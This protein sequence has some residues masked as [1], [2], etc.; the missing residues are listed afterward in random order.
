M[1]VIKELFD[2]MPDGREVYSYTI[3]NE[4]G[5]FVRFL[6]YGGI[7]QA[8]TVPDK[9]GVLGDV[10][11]GF[12]TIGDYRKSGDYHGAMVG[13]YCNRIDHGTFLLNGK[14][15]RLFCNEK[16]KQHLH[17]GNV[18]YNARLWYAEILD[19]ETVRFSLFSPDGDEGYPGNMTVRVTC[20]FDGY[21]LSL[22][23]E[24]TT[25]ADTVCSLTNHAYF[26]LNGIGGSSL[27]DQ[28]LWINADRYCEV[29]DD[30]IPVGAPVPVGKTL[31]DYTSPKKLATPIDHNSVLRGGERE[32][33]RAAMVCDPASGRALIVTTDL[34][35]IQVYTAGGMDKPVPFK[36][37][38]PQRPLHAIALETQFFPDSPNRPDFPSPVLKAGETFRSETVYSFGLM[39][40]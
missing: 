39:E 28:L 19:E 9:N 36:G 29:N 31:F 33:K 10:V 21:N 4:N 3:R 35:G 25:D 14:E 11:C 27:E 37:G 15:Y 17:G 18:S 1:S 2:R 26:N 20:S 24:A 32:T 30:L 6:E 23:Y 13:R 8:L 7:V 40:E 5:S 22:R 34:P 38:V 16:G 12:D